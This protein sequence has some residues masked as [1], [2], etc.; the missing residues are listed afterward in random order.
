MASSI[1]GTAPPFLARL[2]LDADADAR[3]IRRAYAREL[4]RIDQEAQPDAFQHLR[5]CYE[6]ALDWA[7]RRA[8]EGAAAADGQ[9]ASHAPDEAAEHGPDEAPDEAQDEA[10]DEAHDG[11]PV[12]HRAPAAAHRHVDGADPFAQARFVFDD[13]GAAVARLATAP[14]AAGTDAW[15]DLLRGAADDPRLAHLEAR[16]VFEMHLAHLLASGWQPGHEHLLAAAAAVFGWD[17]DRRALARLRQAGQFLDVALDQQAA[18]DGQPPKRRA[19]QGQVLGWLRRPDTPSEDT[20]WRLAGPLRTLAE[21]FP[22]WLSV[23]APRAATQR[24]LAACAEPV[25]ASGAAATPA[26]ATWLARLRA[27]LTPRGWGLV[28]YLCLSLVIALANRTPKPTGFY[29]PVS[30]LSSATSPRRPPAA[31]PDADVPLTT[32]QVEAIRSHIRYQPKPGMPDTDRVMFQVYLDADGKVFG[33]N[34]VVLPADPAYAA[35]V[36]RAIRSIEPYPADTVKSFRLGFRRVKDASPAHPSSDKAG[37]AGGAGAS[38]ASTTGGK[39]PA[40]WSRRK[41]L[42]APA[43]E[44]DPTWQRFAEPGGVEQWKQLGPDKASQAEPEQPER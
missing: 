10:Q 21:H 33:M 29:P 11:M 43:G 6:R 44:P 13:L 15:L 35:A 4:K 41:A 8:G 42:D 25:D 32:A 30:A 31:V 16:T 19:V 38:R 14:D 7:E 40:P 28:F 1:H 24:W 27:R 36:E 34:K 23:V 2:A 37:A 17:T 9:A 20:M 26:D 3:A 22:Q 39:A 5:E 18:F 12:R